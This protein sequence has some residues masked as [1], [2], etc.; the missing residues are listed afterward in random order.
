[1]AAN[2]ANPMKTAIRISRL[3]VGGAG[4]QTL[5]AA[6]Q[7]GKRLDASSRRRQVAKV[8]PLVIGG[9]DLQDL[10]AKH[11]AGCRMDKRTKSPVMHAI[12]QWPT[13]LAVTE[14]TERAMITH[15]HKFLNDLLGGEAVFAARLDRDERGKHVVDVFCSPVVTKS[16]GSRWVQTGKHL[17]TL[18]ERHRAE[19]ERRHDKITDITSPRCQGIAL[20]SEWRNYVE[21]LGLKL[22]AKREKNHGANDWKTPEAYALA[23]REAAVAAR[24]AALREDER[25]LGEWLADS[26]LQREAH[27]NELVMREGQLA[28]RE[29]FLER[30]AEE[31]GVEPPTTDLD[32]RP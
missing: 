20:Q 6:E 7:H 17:K 4:R 3:R 1:M 24:E 11:T 32:Y 15:A 5:D 28:Y 25:K 9:I 30:W 10:Y 16:D 2:P 13:G 26:S 18:C 14:Q 19:I 8:A 31:N 29:E 22:E 27:E 21:G 12:V 23:A